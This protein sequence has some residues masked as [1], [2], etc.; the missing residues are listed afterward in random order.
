MSRVK[1]LEIQLNDLIKE[2]KVLKLK[3][4]IK[5]NTF[6]I[7][8]IEQQLQ[9]CAKCNRRTV[10]IMQ[11]LNDKDL[12]NLVKEHTID[13]INKCPNKIILSISAN[14]MKEINNQLLMCEI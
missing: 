2:N 12:F 1:D 14:E 5:S 11:Y 9:H 3:S 4:G 13:I 6:I 7:Q 8:L 10:C